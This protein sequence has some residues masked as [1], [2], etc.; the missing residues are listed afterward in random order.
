LSVEAVSASLDNVGGITC[1]QGHVAGIVY[2]S[3]LRR[4]IHCC[5]VGLRL[6]YVNVAIYILMQS[7]SDD[8]TRRTI[9]GQCNTCI[10][11]SPVD[12]PTI[13]LTL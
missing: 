12:Y 3:K 4:W 1:R 9:S 13:T 8:C 11:Q 5:Q 7:A 6:Y 2:V 10:I